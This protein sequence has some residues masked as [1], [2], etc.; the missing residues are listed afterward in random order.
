[1]AGS[2]YGD[3]TCILAAFGAVLGRPRGLDMSIVVSGVL[4]AMVVAV[5][6]VA[7]PLLIASLWG[8]F[9]NRIPAA[10]AAPRFSLARRPEFLTVARASA[11][12]VCC[13]AGRLTSTPL[14]APPDFLA[15]LTRGPTGPIPA[16][17]AR[18]RSLH[19]L[20]CIRPE[21]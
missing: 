7:G 10:H 20:R 8:P 21:I 15:S 2:P 9:Q 6:L 16:T 1:M 14:R 17:A 4:T 3:L 19:P 5:L 18:T 11:P 13:F 12:A